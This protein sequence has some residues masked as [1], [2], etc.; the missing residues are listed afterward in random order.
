MDSNFWYNLR[1]KP[2]KTEVDNLLLDYKRRLNIISEYLV[3]NSKC[4]ISDEN[5]IQEIR[6][7]INNCER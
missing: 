2:N 7:I 1:H 4:D 6:E 5:C 3:S